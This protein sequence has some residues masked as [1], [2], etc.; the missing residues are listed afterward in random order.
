[1][2]DST[3]IGSLE[4]KEKPVPQDDVSSVSEDV[5]SKISNVLTEEG[6][7]TIEVGKAGKTN[8][9]LTKTNMQNPQRLIFQQL[10]ERGGEENLRGELPE[11]GTDAKNIASQASAKLERF[12]KVLRFRNCI[13][14]FRKLRKE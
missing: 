1:M 10:P 12:L 13:N 14:R 8:N 2:C 4:G 11:P 7:G 5:V 3:G 6:G 9:F